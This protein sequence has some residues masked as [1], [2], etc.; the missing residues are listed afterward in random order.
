MALCY[1]REPVRAESVGS[2][3]MRI[4]AAALFLV[5]GTVAVFAGPAVGEEKLSDLQA[6]M[7]AIQA[8]L[9]ATSERVSAAYNLRKDLE[10]QLEQLALKIDDTEAKRTKLRAKVAERAAEIYKDGGTSTLEILLESDDFADLTNN[11]ELLSQISADETVDFVN[12][13]RSEDELRL[14]QE[15][16]AAKSELLSETQE[17]LEE[18]AEQLQAQLAAVSDEYNELREKLAVAQAAQVPAASSAPVDK[19]ADS[20]PAAEAPAPASFASSDGMYCPVGGP[21][22]FS[23]TYGAPRS[24]GRSHEGVDM[25]AAYGTPQIAIVS[26]TIT[27]AGYSALGGNVQYLSGDDGNLYVYVHQAEN[28]VTSG[29]VQAGQQISTVGDTGNAAGIPHLHFEFHPGG[30]APANPTP[31]VSSLC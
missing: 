24:G 4:G 29:H 7:D 23:D 3:T 15:E 9:D 2:K 20:A 31:L 1:G 8:D 30:G 28:L 5:L 21:V 6:R 14:L 19:P 11:A 27:Y 13:A 12:L 18:D 17:T 26:G 10:H 25:M 16:A 22:S